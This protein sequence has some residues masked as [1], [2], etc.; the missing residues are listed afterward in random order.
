MGIFG[1]PRPRQ[2]QPTVRKD[3]YGIE[4]PPG[5]HLQPVDNEGKKF[6]VVNNTGVDSQ[7]PVDQGAYAQKRQDEEDSYLNEEDSGY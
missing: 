2:D 3:M 7:A 5:H 6:A 1:Q 4:I